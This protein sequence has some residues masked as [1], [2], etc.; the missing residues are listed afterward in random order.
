MPY[1]LQIGVETPSDSTVIWRYF[2]LPKLLLLLEN[3]SLY[4]A[5][6]KKLDD[7]WE[8]IISNRYRASVA[9]YAPSA[10]GT[11]IEMIQSFTKNLGVSCWHIDNDESIAMWSLYT[12]WKPGSRTDCYGTAIK[13]SVGRLKSAFEEAREK[14]VIGS[15]HY[16]N[17][18]ADLAHWRPPLDGNTAFDPAFQKR[19]CYRHEHELRASIIIEPDPPDP[20]PLNGASVHIDLDRLIERIVLCPGFP[21]FGEVLLKSALS[22]AGINPILAVSSLPKLPSEC[23]FS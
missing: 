17:H 18:D 13:T 23:G 7:A 11:L 12:S 9:S 6:I 19:A 15:V 5:L 21:K 2:D 22:R 8:C 3:R 4:F 16:E 14:V 20:F 1:Q 10:S